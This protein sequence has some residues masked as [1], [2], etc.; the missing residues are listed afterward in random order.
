MKDKIADFYRAKLNEAGG[1]EASPLIAE[2]DPALFDS[3]PEGM[4]SS[5]FGCGDP[6]AFATAPVGGT[7]VDLG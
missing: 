5:R 6:R 4:A 7:F 3:A 1:D 2:Y